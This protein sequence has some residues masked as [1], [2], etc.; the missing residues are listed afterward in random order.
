MK[1]T[2]KTKRYLAV[3]GGSMI[4]IALIAV[5]SLQFGKT[6][7]GEDVLPE[8]T[9]MVTEIV[10]D[11]GIVQTEEAKA[12]IEQDIKPE[13]DR[14]T[15]TIKETEETVHPVDSRPAQTDQ[16]EQSIQPDVIRP[17]APSEDVLTNPTQMP[18]GTKVESP[19]VPVEHDAVVTPTE[20]A[21]KPDEPQAGD[22]KNGQIYIP[23]FGWVQNN[24]G[25]GSGTVAEDMY[26]NGNKIGIM[27]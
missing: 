10:V 1:L 2:E 14:I 19:P 23:G 22:T 16:T 24:G 9:S 7:S 3:G 5:I 25:G 17:E 27:D 15:D 26:E 20:P 11:S 12:D 4:C 21:A 18:D 8:E 6:S 13:T